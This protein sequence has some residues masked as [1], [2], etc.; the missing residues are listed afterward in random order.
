MLQAGSDRGW[1]TVEFPQHFLGG[2]DAVELGFLENGY[3]A[4]VGVGEEDA[5]IKTRQ[6]VAFFGKN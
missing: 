3:A 6:A 5:A 1:L 2:F 4:E